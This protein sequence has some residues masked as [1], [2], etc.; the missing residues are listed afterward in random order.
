[1]TVDCLLYQQDAAALGKVDC[2][3]EHQIATE[4]AIS[5]YPTLK[6]F[7]NGKVGFCFVNYCKEKEYRIPTFVVIPTF[8]YPYCSKSH[9]DEATSLKGLTVL[10]MS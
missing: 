6:V 5:K 10:R 8:L 4:N 2:E 9:S 7:R 1:M 3:T